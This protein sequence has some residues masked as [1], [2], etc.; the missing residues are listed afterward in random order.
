MKTQTVHQDLHKQYLSSY[1]T[2]AGARY[3]FNQNFFIDATF[4]DE[5]KISKF[6]QAL[7]LNMIINPLHLHLTIEVI[8]LKEQQ[9]LMGS[10]EIDLILLHL[11]EL[12]KIQLQKIT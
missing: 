12:L 5:D 4:S 11:L 3:D 1:V 6:G 8:F 7:I 9:E 10:K 2:T